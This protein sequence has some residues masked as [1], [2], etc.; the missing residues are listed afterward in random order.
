MIHLRAA[1]LAIPGDP[2][3]SSLLDDLLA[4]RSRRG[5]PTPPERPAA[6]SANAWRR[7]NPL[8]RLVA[9]VVSPLLP[10]LDAANVAIVFGVY[11]GEVVATSKFLERLYEEGPSAASPLAF[12]NSVYN[13]PIGHLSINHGLTGHQET[14]SAGGASGLAAVH[15]AVDLLTLGVAEAVIVAAAD[16]VNP[17]TL[18]AYELAEHPIAPGEMAAAILLSRQGPGPIVSLGDGDPEAL[19]L[20]RTDPMPGERGFLPPSG[21]SYS[22]L[23]GSNA[24]SGLVALAALSAVGRGT[25]RDVDGDIAWTVSLQ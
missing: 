4:G 17:T 1:R 21:A 15:R 10:G 16:D 5:S 13:A 6:I 8:D 23:L 12:Q 19:I 11:V 18:R 2:D 20:A 9:S 7:M 14:V 24:A 3:P 22:A 25:V